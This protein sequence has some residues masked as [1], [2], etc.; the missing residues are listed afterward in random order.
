MELFLSTV[1]FL[2]HV[3]KQWS[4]Q[5][6]KTPH[7]FSLVALVTPDSQFFVCFISS[8]CVSYSATTHPSCCNLQYVTKSASFFKKIPQRNGKISKETIDRQG[9]GGGRCFWRSANGITFRNTHK[10]A[11]LF[12]HCAFSTKQV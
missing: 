4:I 9:G 12:L 6:W 11:H 10:N 8:T 7:M 5:T 3:W 1:S 2:S